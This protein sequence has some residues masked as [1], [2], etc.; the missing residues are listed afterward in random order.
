MGILSKIIEFLLKIEENR[1]MREVSKD[2]D[3]KRTEV[4]AAVHDAIFDEIRR[5]E[6][7]WE[8]E[9]RALEQISSE[10]KELIRL[11]KIYQKDLHRRKYIILAA[12]LVLAMSMSVTS[13]GGVDRMFHKI[14]SMICGRSRETV[15]TEG[16]KTLAEKEEEAFAEIE[17]MYGIV[18]VRMACLPSDW[19]FLEAIVLRDTLQVKVLYGVKGEIRVDYD[20]VLNYQEG[21]WSRDIEDELVREYVE[22]REGIEI[23]IREFEVENRG[24]RWLLQFTH[25]DLHYRIHIFDV[26]KEEM[27]TVLDYLYF[28]A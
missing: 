17:E 9:R 20:I 12:I 2:K 10:N 1:I 25:A 24:T 5:K 7:K 6:E 16:V 3:L 4:P 8:T 18:P 13:F 19:E 22:Y 14:S 11:G 27:Q 21:S 23:D 28:P 15:D 26:E